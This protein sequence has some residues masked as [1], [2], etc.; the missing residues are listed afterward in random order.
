M[1][2][3]FGNSKELGD[4]IIPLHV[5]ALVGGGDDAK[6]T[7]MNSLVIDEEKYQEFYRKH[8][9]SVLKKIL[10]SKLSSSD[11]RTKLKNEMLEK[12]REEAFTIST[13][14]ECEDWLRRARLVNTGHT[15]FSSVLRSRVW[16]TP[17]SFICFCMDNCTETFRPGNSVFGSSLYNK[18]DAPASTLPRESDEDEGEDVDEDD[19]EERPRRGRATRAVAVKTPDYR[20]WF[21]TSV[22][23]RTAGQQ[24]AHLFSDT[25]FDFV[26]TLNYKTPRGVKV[27]K[28]EEGKAKLT[29]TVDDDQRIFMMLRTVTTK[30]SEFV[31]AD[32]E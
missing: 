19:W 14:E 9:P 31:D 5:V 22:E 32:Q 10:E 25:P 16:T 7:A 29:M 2:S 12:L 17:A 28:N 27:D 4:Q 11:R 15:I 3:F 18:V 30:A 23:G 20:Y 26:N 21:K 1:V 24:I 8:L 6:W 13:F